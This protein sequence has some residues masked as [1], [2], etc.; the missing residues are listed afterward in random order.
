MFDLLTKLFYHTKQTWYKFTTVAVFKLTETS[1]QVSL[2]LSMNMICI[3]ISNSLNV[4][5]LKICQ[6]YK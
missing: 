2:P 5:T 4:W 1:I 3:E 6:Y